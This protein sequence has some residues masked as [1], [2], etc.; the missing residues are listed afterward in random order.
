MSAPSLPDFP[1]DRKIPTGEDRERLVCRDC[2]FINY[3]NPKVIVGAVCTWEDKFLLC[4]RAIPPRM[5]YWT[6]PAGYMELHE[7]AEQGAA[8]EAIEEANAH[9][10]IDA[11]LA[12][13]S[14]PRISQVQL[15]YRARLIRP[16]FSPGPESLDVQL[17]SYDQIPWDELAF[18]SVTWALQHFKEVEGL[19]S[20]APF[21]VP[22]GELDRL[23]ESGSRKYDY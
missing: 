20:F 10:A 19:T 21:Q 18:P 9:I 4:K 13:Y 14:I 16:E 22:T 2:G 8:R 6:M 15:I 3:E 11:L 12:V 23:R 5:G 17:F 7:T 1:F